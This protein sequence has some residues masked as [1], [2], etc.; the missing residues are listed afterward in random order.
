MGRLANH[1]HRLQ[2]V[3]APLQSRHKREIG[4]APA[5]AGSFLKLTR[6]WLV[7]GFV[8]GFASSWEVI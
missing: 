1:S 5:G 4:D 8:H 7:M 3:R 6:A 2:F